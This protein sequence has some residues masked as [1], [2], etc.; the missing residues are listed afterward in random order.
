[1]YIYGQLSEVQMVR[2]L[3]L[4]LGSGQGHINMHSTCRTT[5]RPNHVKY[6]RNMAIWISSNIDIGR[7]LNSRDSF[8]RWKFKNRAPTSCSQ[9]PILWPPAISFELHAEMAEEIDLEKC[10]FRNF[11]RSVTLT[12]TLD[13]VEVTLVR[14]CG[15]G[16][17]THQIR[18]KSE[19]KLFVDVRTDGHLSEQTD[20]RA[21][22]P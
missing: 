2:D 16:L 4:D 3:D 7:S 15:R 18:W 13:R 5:C 14:I 1:M 12:L 6:G 10:T 22:M 21:E 17:P 8:P 11:G 19:K 20:R 9:G